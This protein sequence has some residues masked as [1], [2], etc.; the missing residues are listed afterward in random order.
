MK[1][2]A[3]AQVLRLWQAYQTIKIR[4]ND[5]KIATLSSGYIITACNPE[6]RVCSA[7]QNRLKTEKLQRYLESH[8]ISAQPVLVGDPDFNW[9]EPSFCC[10]LDEKHAFN[11]ARQYQQ[12]AIYQIKDN[13]LWLIPVLLKQLAVISLGALKN[14]ST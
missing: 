1:K 3:Y 8:K 4:G 9:V 10:A 11:L 5:G 2:N 6:S 14:F 7:R 12:N 13:E